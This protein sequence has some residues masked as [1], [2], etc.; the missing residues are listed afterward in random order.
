MA[1]SPE[2]PEPA[3]RSDHGTKIIHAITICRPADDLHRAMLD[4]AILAQVI[5]APARLNWLSPEEFEF[6][7]GDAIVTTGRIINQKPGELLAWQ[8]DP[9]GEFPHAGTIRLAKAPADEGTELILQVEYEA[10]LAEKLGKFFGKDPGSRA[11]QM[12]R[13]FKA[14]V[15][16]GEIPT[17]AGQAAGNPQRKNQP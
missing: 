4:R 15:E 3:V 14:L 17:I 7:S 16:A 12:L 2:Q 11:K 5:P 9:A 13:R 10:T 8:T 6:W 1:K